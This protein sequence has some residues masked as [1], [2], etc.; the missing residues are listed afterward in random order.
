MKNNISYEL[1]N[2]IVEE[3]LHCI[4]T[5]IRQNWTLIKAARLERDDVYQQLAM[6]LIRCVGT[7]DPNKGELKQHIYAQLK[8]ELLNCKEIRRLTGITGAPKGFCRG[9]VISIDAL[10]DD[11]GL[12]QECLAA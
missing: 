11:Y 12:Y 10:R 7:Y 1:R 6:R 2:R 3:H 5:V 4:D 8:Y 9:N